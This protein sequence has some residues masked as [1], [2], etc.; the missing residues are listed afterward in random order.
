MVFDDNKEPHKQA[1]EKKLIQGI[2]GNIGVL[3]GDVCLLL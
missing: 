1:P 3:T 2:V